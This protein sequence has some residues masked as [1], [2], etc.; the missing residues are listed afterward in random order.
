MIENA[1]YQFVVF[2]WKLWNHV[3]PHSPRHTTMWPTIEP[4]I[5]SLKP[6]LPTTLARL[7]LWKGISNNQ[8]NDLHDLFALLI[9][10]AINIVLT[11]A[12]A[13]NHIAAFCADSGEPDTARR[14]L[15]GVEDVQHKRSVHCAGQPFYLFKVAF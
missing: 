4:G 9:E 2:F 3:T 6:T 7:R 13:N 15:F 8:A 14:S 12:Q 11:I 5:G 1:T 10:E